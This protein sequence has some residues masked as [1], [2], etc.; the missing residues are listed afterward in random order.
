M[1]KEIAIIILAGGKSTRMK[2][3]KGMVSFMGKPLIFHMLEIAKQLSDDIIIIAN[4]EE[5]RL[6]GYPC[7]EDVIKDSGPIA[8]IYTGLVNTKKRKNLVLSCDS[9]FVD[10]DFLKDMI[11]SYGNEDVLVPKH[12]DRIEPLSAIYD[13]NCTDIFKER[14]SQGK[15]KMMDALSSVNSTLFEV[16]EKR[17]DSKWLFIN[18]N[19]ME[20]LSSAEKLKGFNK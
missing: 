6:L 10:V 8:G 1:N 9:P 14:L 20:E 13:W 4:K 19:S 16:N 3:D 7:F 12:K 2:T 17:W 18:L 5:Y 11:A 15:F